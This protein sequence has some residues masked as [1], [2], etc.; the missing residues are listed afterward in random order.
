MSVLQV[1]R[2]KSSSSEADLLTAILNA[3]GGLERWN[4][5]KKVEATILSGGGFYPLKGVVPDT[6]PRRATVWLH[7]QRSSVTPFGAPDQRTMLTSER[8][9]IER[10]D[11]TLVAERKAQ[12]IRLLGTRCIRH[13]ILYTSPISTARRCGPT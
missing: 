6:I 1:K 10:L 5:Y 4:K 9:A 12:K 11:G 13:G 2:T 3:H 7:E 8:I